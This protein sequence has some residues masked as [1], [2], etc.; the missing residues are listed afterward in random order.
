MAETQLQRERSPTL[1]DRLSTAWNKT[2]KE[3]SLRTDWLT[4]WRPWCILWHWKTKEEDPR[5]E[6]GLRHPVDILWNALVCADIWSGGL[7]ED[8]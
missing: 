7:I 6:G 3:V 1:A 4:K 5:N 2:S 8:I